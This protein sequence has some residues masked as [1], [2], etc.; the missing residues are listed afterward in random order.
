MTVAIK[1][2]REQLR[3]AVQEEYAAV[4]VCPLNGFH[5]HTGRYL[6]G[7]LGY[8]E[9]ELAALPD[10]VVESFA[11]VGNPFSLGRL[12]PGEVVVEVGSGAGLDSLLAAQ[13]VGPAGR[14][15]GV[16]MT[17]AMLSK[18]RENSAL[19]GAGNLEFREGFAEHL[20]V[21]SASADVVISNG[22]LNLCP[23]KDAAWKEIFRVLKPGGR[24]QIADIIVRKPVPE[25]GKQDIALWT[26]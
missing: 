17:E 1:L 22:V 15:I 16:D 21:A 5:F 19:V 8:P 23:D 2:D 10:S 9:P 24:F 13:Q 25:E 11:G 3:R 26:G 18:A 14:V 6:A 12:D 4:A 7:L 20:P